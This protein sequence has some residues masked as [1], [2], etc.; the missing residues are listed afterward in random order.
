MNYEGKSIIKTNKTKA[1]R[2]VFR[3]QDFWTHPPKSNQMQSRIRY[4]IE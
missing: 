3:G 2:Y 1:K 4:A